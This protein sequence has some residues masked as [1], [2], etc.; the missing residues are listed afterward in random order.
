MTN[1][2]AKPD[3]SSLDEIIQVLRE[4]VPD[5]SERYN[6]KQLGVFGSYVRGEADGESDLDIL[7]EFER[8]PTLWAFIRL[9]RELSDK[10]GVK[11]DMVMKKTLKPR[12]G[13][14]VLKEVV[15]V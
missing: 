5:L 4:S 7:V 15:A 10:L 13:K 11:V 6:V 14:E 8:A 9:E 2:I 1:E 12:I 3:S